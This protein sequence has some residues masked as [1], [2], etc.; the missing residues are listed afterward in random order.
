M[1][2]FVR[3]GYA[4]VL[5]VVLV[6]GVVVAGPAT[7]AWAAD[8]RT[9]CSVSGS[10]LVTSDG[11]VEDGASC[12]GDA[13]IPSSPVAPI[14][15]GPAAF[16]ASLV[17]SVEIPAS[18]AS[19]SSLA[20]AETPLLT[21]VTFNGVSQLSSIGESAFQNS[22]LVLIDIPASVTSIGNFA[23][24]YN[25]ALTSV[26]FDGVSRVAS[27]G[28]GAFQNGGLRSI[29]IPASV[30]SIGNF[31]FADNAALTSVTFEGNAPTIGLLVFTNGAAGAVANVGFA[32]TGFEPVVSGRWQGLVLVRDAAPSE[33]SP[34]STAAPGTGGIFLY[35]AGSPGR[36]VEG[37]PVYHGSAGVA[38]NTSYT[39]SVQSMGARALTRTVLATG[40]T[41]G[42]GHVEGRIRLGALAPGSYKI[43]MTG[44]HPLGH[45]LVLTNHISVDAAGKFVSVSPESLQPSLK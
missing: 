34:R 18:V 4:L 23:F 1:S 25:A 20:F 42:R 32:A 26:S 45:A 2:R 29:A 41:N 37:T 9:N 36:V 13:V 27:L 10:F 7:V 3:K 12:T 40:V 38:P 15:I 44:T 31:A 19:I 39:L 14:E 28:Q 5:A 8:T 21:S 11:V 16:N 6:S 24:A 35:I 33:S 30:T 43:V 22:G 17:V